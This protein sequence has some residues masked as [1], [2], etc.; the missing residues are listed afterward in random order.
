MDSS[1]NK[2]VRLK[3]FLRQQTMNANSKYLSISADM[4]P[5]KRLEGQVI[6]FFCF[7]GFNWAYGIFRLYSAV[8]FLSMWLLRFFRVQT[9][10]RKCCG[11]LNLA[12][13]LV[14]RY[15]SDVTHLLMLLESLSNYDDDDNVK[16]QFSPAAQL[17]IFSELCTFRYKHEFWHTDSSH[18][19][20]HFQVQCQ[21]GSRSPQKPQCIKFHKNQ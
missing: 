14:Q 11:I 17:E 7:V 3:V 18:Q 20:K 15:S 9:Y 21:A 8:F 12:A 13:F 2:S 5:E 4:K 16:K 10:C 19:Y 1:F 6:F